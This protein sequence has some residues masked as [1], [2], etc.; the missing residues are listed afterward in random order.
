MVSNEDKSQPL[1]LEKI[2]DP[3]KL[4]VTPETHQIQQ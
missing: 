3:S 4:E 1:K 2:N